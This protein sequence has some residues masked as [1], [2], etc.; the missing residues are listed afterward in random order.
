MEKEKSNS[1][2][3]R[4]LAQQQPTWALAMRGLIGRHGLAHEAHQRPTALG[5]AGPRG[6]TKKLPISGP[7]A[8]GLPKRGLITAYF[9]KP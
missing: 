1:I 3:L 7:T 4:K 6:L 8:V 5:L 9:G 2:S